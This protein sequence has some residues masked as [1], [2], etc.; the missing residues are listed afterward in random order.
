MALSAGMAT[1]MLASG[2]KKRDHNITNMSIYSAMVFMMRKY[3][4]IP[5][6]CP[7][8]DVRPVV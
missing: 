7:N 5:Q 6:E 2:N 8:W 4:T 1:A 3:P